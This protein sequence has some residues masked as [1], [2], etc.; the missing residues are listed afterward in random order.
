MRTY[1]ATTKIPAHT[2]HVSSLL[3]EKKWTN[4]V[5]QFYYTSTNTPCPNKEA[6]GFAI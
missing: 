2:W 5:F 3:S 6:S 4:R 1:N